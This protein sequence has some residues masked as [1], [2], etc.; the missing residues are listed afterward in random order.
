MSFLPPP[1]GLP[2]PPSASAGLPPPPPPASVKAPLPAAS[3]VAKSAVAAPAKPSVSVPMAAAKPEKGFVD[4]SVRVEAENWQ[5]KYLEGGV[6]VLDVLTGSPSLVEAVARTKDAMG[7]RIMMFIGPT[8]A[9]KSTVVNYLLGHELEII[10]TPA[11]DEHL[12]ITTGKK[13]V[14]VAALGGAVEACTLYPECYS[15]PAADLC[16]CDCPGFF[17]TRGP[18]GRII[19]NMSNDMVAKS[20]AAIGGIVMLVED[21]ALYG[22]KASGFRE[23]AMTLGHMI[24][25]LDKKTPEELAYL[26]SSMTVIYNAKGFLHKRNLEK[27]RLKLE[28]LLASERP[29]LERLHQQSLLPG[30]SSEPQVA[31]ADA[32]SKVMVMTFMKDLLDAGRFVM[33]DPLDSGASREQILR[34][35]RAAPGIDKHFLSFSDMDPAQNQM[36]EIMIQIAGE[37]NLLMTNTHIAGDEMVYYRKRMTE[38]FEALAGIQKQLDASSNQGIG[39][40]ETL[41]N[42]R[43][44]TVAALKTKR[45]Q[46]AEKEAEA[47]ALTSDVEALKR[48]LALVD[49]DERTLCFEQEHE[50][51]TAGRVARA[52]AWTVGF[53]AGIGA[54][55]LAILDQVV[56]NCGISHG[57]SKFVTCKKIEYHGVPFNEIKLSPGLEGKP[58]TCDKSKGVLIFQIDAISSTSGLHCL[59]LYTEKRLMS[60]NPQKIALLKK[61]LGIGCDEG[62]LKSLARVLADIAGLQKKIR[63]D[64]AFLVSLSSD[65]DSIKDAMTARKAQLE[66][67]REEINAERRDITERILPAKQGILEANQA[68]FRAGLPIY[69]LVQQV[70]LAL[71]FHMDRNARFDGIRQFMETMARDGAAVA[72]SAGVRAGA[73]TAFAG[74]MTGGVAKARNI[75]DASPESEVWSD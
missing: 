13:G 30:V 6:K 33:V 9:G 72:S 20:S 11:G 10:E 19:T 21:A 40:V 69:S 41:A 42:S 16:Y 32:F 5:D 23:L 31:Y 51:S 60:G 71:C 54:F 63:E 70:A 34:C 47:R 4:R 27:I 2:R 52:T 12:Q 29:K 28:E 65:A 59:Q 62:K 74:A 49:T 53:F 1:P 15:D 39:F 61:Q 66:G 64:E 45:E 17:D 36:T 68:H 22:Q 24:K 18:L 57:I 75:A 55:P 25:D 8:G 73:T 35:L 37:A 58:E 48:Q 7:K 67:R 46:L 38:L 26:K 14:P 43:G 3:T 44:E 50:I 56:F